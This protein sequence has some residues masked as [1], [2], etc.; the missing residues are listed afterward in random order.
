[1][2]PSVSRS[3]VVT[4]GVEEEFLLTGASDPATVPRAASVLARVA[5]ELG[6]HAEPEFYRTQVETSTTPCQFGG[7]IRK[8]LAGARRVLADAAGD[9]DARLVASATAVTGAT[10]PPIADDPR[11]QA[12]ARR[13]RDVL[14]GVTT[15]TC[16]CHVHLGPFDRD[17][18]VLLGTLL[19]PWLPMLQ[20]LAA[21][22]PFAGGQDRGC[23]SWRHFEF[24]RW[25]TVGPSPVLD[26]PGY[27]RTARELTATGAVMDR[28][29][30][31]WYA[32]PS[33]RW[34]TV[35]I[36]VADVN[37]DLD[38]PVLLAV[39]ARG[40][41]QTLLA[42]LRADKPVP[43]PGNDHRLHRDHHAAALYG[44]ES[45]GTDPVD[46]SDALL[47]QRLASLID[48]AA[49]GLRATDELELAQALLAAVLA[50][51][52]GAGQ[53]RRDYLA[54]E[55]LADVVDGLAERTATA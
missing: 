43:G 8:E 24:A 21:N 5:G 15:E 52:G 30:I 38:V 4:I 48:F 10:P 35:E 45:E 14:A 41:A 51:G 20:G 7:Q 34:P 50:H 37:D 49:P 26:G 9:L 1:M 46:G 13:Y 44:L 25:P 2:A 19:R 17:H 36:R 39:L 6:P 33:E 29:M 12:M 31:Y 27:E 28:K 40:L 32:R 16:G 18:A 47:P 54:R 22:S 42:R 23:A 3:D 55:S 11:Y 53:Q